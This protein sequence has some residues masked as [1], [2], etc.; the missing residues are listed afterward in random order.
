MVC[1]AALPCRSKLPSWRHSRGKLIIRE[2]ETASN[3]SSVNK[4][5]VYQTFGQPTHLTHPH[6]V[7]K[8]EVCMIIHGAHHG[9]L[10]YCYNQRLYIHCSINVDC[11]RYTTRGT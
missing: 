4:K 2:I 11:S 3:L 5:A 9:I 10:Y 8:G 1:F 6:R 7:S